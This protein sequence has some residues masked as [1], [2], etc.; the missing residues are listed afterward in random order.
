MRSILVVAAAVVSLAI[1]AAAFAAFSESV[2]P[3]TTATPTELSPTEAFVGDA[4]DAQQAA[5]ES[6]SARSASTV[7]GEYVRRTFRTHFLNTSQVSGRAAAVRSRVGGG[8]LAYGGRAEF[9]TVICG[10]SCQTVPY[11]ESS[12]FN[13]YY[14][15]L[16]VFAHG[17]PTRT[18]VCRQQRSCSVPVSRT[19]RT[20]TAQARFC[21][22]FSNDG[23]GTL[24]TSY[25][26]ATR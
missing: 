15:E 4:D 7:W 17:G 14:V 21:G 19:A 16:R 25:S 3:A 9:S 10:Y 2:P 12:K 22:D 18:V 23:A 1:P 6:I 24:C 5:V 8:G 26:T 13:S 11:I 20:V